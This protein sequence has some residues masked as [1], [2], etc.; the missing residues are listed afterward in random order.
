MNRED[1][2]EK[3]AEILQYSEMWTYLM[4]SYHKPEDEETQKIL[5]QDFNN[6]LDN[7]ISL[8]ENK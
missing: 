2:K 7:I 8:F 5:D 1:L 3:I 6:I 4:D